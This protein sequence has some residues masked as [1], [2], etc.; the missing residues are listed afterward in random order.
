MSEHHDAPKAHEP[1]AQHET[2]TKGP[3]SPDTI[4]PK[5]SSDI[6]FWA[7][8]FGVTSQ[9]LHEAIRSHGTHVAKVRAALHA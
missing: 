2:H 1:H 6:A 4:N 7:H 5:I 3:S 9:A 8:E